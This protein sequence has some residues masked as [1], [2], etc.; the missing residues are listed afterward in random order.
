M[1][2]GVF[3]AQKLGQ[4][5]PPGLRGTLFTALWFRCFLKAAPWAS[6]LFPQAQTRVLPTLLSLTP[7]RGILDSLLMQVHIWE[8]SAC[9][10]LDVLRCT[11]IYSGLTGKESLGSNQE[12]HYI[13]FKTLRLRTN[14]YQTAK[15][16][17]L[18]WLF[19]L[20]FFVLYNFFCLV[21]LCLVFYP[22]LS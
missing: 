5:P 8:L 18:P 11:W 14:L 13:S 6:G 10:Y 9:L 17:F 22:L 20:E 2:P 3:K 7:R 21:L 19:F 4:P 1:S 16:N 12:S 15:V